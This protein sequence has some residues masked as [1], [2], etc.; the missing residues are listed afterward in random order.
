MKQ[1]I[2]CLTII[3]FFF[4]GITSI[5]ADEIDLVEM[6]KKEKERKKKET[7][8]PIVI[9]NNN[10]N[11]I[12][13]NNNKAS[14]LSVT[15]M[16]SG[17][18]RLKKKRT[19]PMKKESPVT[20]EPKEYW[21]KKLKKIDDEIAKLEEKIKKDEEL[22]DVLFEK[23][24]TSE[25][26]DIEGEGDENQEDMEMEYAEA[27]DRIRENKKKLDKKRQERQDLRLEAIQSGVPPGWLR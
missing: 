9:T 24:E 10:I 2:C 3:L 15:K 21:Q 20:K 19:T 23:L 7:K 11:T 4:G 25:L 1:L 17:D 27:E 6:S 12:K 14:Y 13:I 8:K 16:E 26:S 5:R 18:S 22:L